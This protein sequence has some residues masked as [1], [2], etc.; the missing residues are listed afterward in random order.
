MKKILNFVFVLIFYTIHGQTLRVEYVERHDLSSQLDSIESPMIRQLI[1]EKTAKPKQ[2]ELLFSEG[3]SIYYKKLVKN[4]ND[5]RVTVVDGGGSEKVFKDHKKRIIVK[6]TNFL[7]RW[8]LIEDSLTSGHVWQ[9]TSDT[10]RI[11]GFMCYRAIND[12]GR[13]IVEAWFTPEIPVSDGPRDYYGLPGLILKVKEGNKSI[14]AT[15]IWQE[16]KNVSIEKP[17]KGKKLTQEEFDKIKKE[18]INELTGGNAQGKVKI[19]R[20]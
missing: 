6:Q 1:L 9:I 19:I 2:Y 17:D 8:F 14:E 15:R 20:M 16:K 7:S 5:D 13:S 18:K 12:N 11:G 4:E 10:M 3:R